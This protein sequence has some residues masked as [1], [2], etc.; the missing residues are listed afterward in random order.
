MRKIQVSLALFWFH[1]YDIRSF[2][3]RTYLLFGAMLTGRWTN[4]CIA[5]VSTV[6]WSLL[7]IPLWSSCRICPLRKPD[8]MVERSIFL[9]KNLC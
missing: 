5:L 3:V 8:E 1:T 4:K 6:R 9:H 2:I 7:T